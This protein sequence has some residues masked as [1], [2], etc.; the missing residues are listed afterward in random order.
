L[1]AEWRDD[2]VWRMG[3][4]NHPDDAG[5]EP[6]AQAATDAAILQAD[7]LTVATFDELGV[8]VDGSEVVDEYCDMATITVIDQMIEQARFA[9]A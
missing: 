3:T 5:Q 6:I 9:R 4:T 2:L 1:L 7:N 8:D